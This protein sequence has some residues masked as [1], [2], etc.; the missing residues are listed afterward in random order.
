MTWLRKYRRWWVPVLLGA[1]VPLALA[2]WIVDGDRFPSTTNKLSEM[3]TFP[4][5]VLELG[6]AVDGF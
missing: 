5:L 6:G 4:V 1:L 2:E 3:R